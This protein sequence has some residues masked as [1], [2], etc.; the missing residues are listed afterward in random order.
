MK[1]WLIYALLMAQ[2]CGFYLNIPVKNRLAQSYG[3]CGSISVQR[4]CNRKT[5]LSSPTTKTNQIR[6]LF[7][8][9]IQQHPKLF[10]K[11]INQAM[12]KDFI[13]FIASSSIGLLS[14][15]VVLTIK[16]LIMALDAKFLKHLPTSVPLIGSLLIGLFYAMDLGVGKSALQTVSN[17]TGER[18]KYQVS[19]KQLF[20]RIMG[21]VTSISCGCS[22]GMAC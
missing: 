21:L 17:I 5:L 15:V 2:V 22:V 20:W 13:L 6:F 19:I 10:F 4:G 16:H 14:A 11:A 18:P 7:F 3:G 8:A 1:Y 12:S 9:T